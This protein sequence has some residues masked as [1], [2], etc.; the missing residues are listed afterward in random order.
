MKAAKEQGSTVDVSAA[1]AKI[2]A[3]EQGSTVEATAVEGE[4]EPTEQGASL[5]AN[6]APQDGAADVDASRRNNSNG[7]MNRFP[8]AVPS[9]TV[10]IGNLFFD[11]TAED[12]KARMEEYGV[13]EKSIIISDARGLSKGLVA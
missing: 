9:P 5:S 10:Y 1:E 11:V 4:I 12:L 8:E 3:T 7:R 6:A 2:E 13:V